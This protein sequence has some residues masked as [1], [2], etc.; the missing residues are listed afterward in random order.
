MTVNNSRDSLTGLEVAVIGMAC[1]FPGAKDLLSFWENLK[2]AKTSLSFLD[3]DELAAAKAKFPEMTSDKNYVPSKGGVINEWDSFDN[4]F[5]NYS[6]S[7]AKVLHPQTRNFLECVWHTLEDAG[8]S[9]IT[10]KQPIGVFCSC[11]SSFYWQA[12]TMLSGIRE[13]IGEFLAT[14]LSDSS[15]ASSITSYKLN[16]TGPSMTLNTACSSSL[17]AI[18]QA[19]RALLMGECSMAIAGGVSLNTLPKL[20][21]VYVE[22]MINSADGI[23]RTFD[24]DAKGTVKGEGAGVVMLKP[25]KKAVADGDKIYA[26]IKGSAINNDGN[27]KVGYAAS[28]VSGQAEVIRKAHKVAQVDFNTIGYIETH[29]TG[30][31]LGDVVELEALREAYGSSSHLCKIGSVKTN[32]GHLDAAAGVAGFIKTVLSLYYKKI[33]PSLNFKNANPGFDFE[34]SPFSVITKIED[35]PAG[36]WPYRAS[37][38]SFGIG[39]TN[40]HVIL[41]VCEHGNNN[42]NKQERPFLIKL[43]A[44]SKNSLIAYSKELAGFLL[45]YPDI[46]INNIAFTLNVRRRQHLYKR[47]VVANDISTLRNKLLGYTAEHFVDIDQ[48][49]KDAQVIFMLPGQG[50]Q[51]VNMGLS[52]YRVEPYFKETV[53]ECFRLCSKQVGH[54]LY[55]SMTEAAYAEEAINNTEYTQLIVFIFQYS[56]TKLLIKW[57]VKPAAFIGHSLGE[58]TVA[59]LTGVLSLKDTVD[60]L[61]YRG[62][63]AVQAPNGKTLFVRISE[64]DLLNYLHRG[65]NV[66][67][68]NNSRSYTLSGSGNNIDA[69]CS[70]FRAANIPYVVLN[71]SIGFHSHLMEQAAELLSMKALDIKVLTPDVPF[72]SNV[73][74]D[75]IKPEQ[76]NDKYWGEQLRSTV[77][78]K[79]GIDT[80]LTTFNNP[81]FVEIG[82]DMVL[83]GIVKQHL[84]YSSVQR[85]VISVMPPK[86]NSENELDKILAAIGKLWMLNIPVNWMELQ[87]KPTVSSVNLPGY[88][89][90]KKRF[91]LNIDSSRAEMVSSLLNP[92]QNNDI[93]YYVPKWE[94]SFLPPETKRGGSESCYLIIAS[95]SH[96]DKIAGSINDACRIIRILPSHQYERKDENTILL[97][98]KG[99][100]H[101]DQLF[102]DVSLNERIRV[103]HCLGLTEPGEELNVN[104]PEHLQNYFYSVL[105]LVK[106]LN[107]VVISQEQEFI[108]LSNKVAD[109]FDN[110]DILPLKY[111][112][113]GA[114]KT[115]SVEYPNV[116][117]KLVDIELTNEPDCLLDINQILAKEFNYFDNRHLVVHRYGSRWVKTIEPIKLNNNDRLL[118]R[119]DKHNYI[120]TGAF[121]GIGL[122]IIKHLIKNYNANI[123]AIVRIGFP[124]RDNWDEYITSNKDEKTRN[125]IK[126]ILDIEEKY[127]THITVVSIDISNEQSISEVISDFE[128]MHGDITGVIHAAGEIDTNGIIQN[129]NNE[130][131]RQVMTAKINGTIAITNYFKNRP[132][133]FLAL[134]SS[135]GNVLYKSKFGQVG[136]I[137]SNEFI[138]AYGVYCNLNFS[139]KTTVIH[140]NDWKEVGLTVEAAKRKHKHEDQEFDVEEHINGGL[141]IAEGLSVF[142][143]AI[144]SG[145]D[146]VIVSTQDL[147]QKVAGYDSEIGGDR[148]NISKRRDSF[149][150]MQSLRKNRD[151][152]DKHLLV[153][154]IFREYVDDP[155][156]DINDDFFEKGGDSLKAIYLLRRLE[157]EFGIEISIHFLYENSTA[158]KIACFIDSMNANVTGASANIIHSFFKPSVLLKHSVGS[159]RVLLLFPPTAAYAFVYEKFASLIEGYSIHGFNFLPETDRNQKYL[160]IIK[161][162]ETSYPFV[163]MGYSAG[164]A[165]AF[166]LCKTMEEGGVEVS[167]L[168]LL[169]TY[170]YRVHHKDGHDAYVFDEFIKSAKSLVS[171]LHYEEY[172]NEII[173]NINA[174]HKFSGELVSSGKINAN[175]HLLKAEDRF[176]EE[177]RFKKLL[178]ER[179]KEFTE[180]S[181]LTNGNYFE[182][183]CF[184][185]HSQLISDNF[186]RQNIIIC[187]KILNSIHRNT[188]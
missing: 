3:D 34:N 121:G 180:W 17:V 29:G 55:P 62:E 140:W 40:A 58:L 142:E 81:V 96:A 60:L 25:Y 45:K 134:F 97:D 67:A 73:T 20:G 135:C 146:N 39:G 11:S 113:L 167:D 141:T 38:S 152:N 170:S 158:F 102:K 91:S 94:Q 174:Y 106:A 14:T 139:F 23:C 70:Q 8:Y 48:Q 136:Y 162:I 127:S 98:I 28:S 148:T 160:E 10:E 41:E 110:G 99:A 104:D 63:L 103:V 6:I 84:L 181:N 21:Y 87:S 85:E 100:E 112:V 166:E 1:N 184:G 169:D 44:N 124:L 93:K 177:S 154:N 88:V 79:K 78:F 90:D 161:G 71:E 178:G 123:L 89:F 144:S 9:H 151:D 26:V 35:W 187:N 107:K 149:V 116:K 24:K 185:K 49:P 105:N 77:Q 16:F 130:S 172:E 30:T 114:V 47:W 52:L 22:G 57:G 64:Q 147:I 74:G 53:D 179:T 86:K 145:Y 75:W 182:Y 5:F 183:N 125:R 27:R 156:Y 129:R 120:V 50:S 18:H 115:I 2:D 109:I 131:T 173:N 176:E 101:Y 76:L 43:T 155:H 54:I 164:G 138:E 13:N 143:Q 95:A 137:S 171:S 132:L 68:I 117:I 56:L 157:R 15:F 165:L 175:I 108:L 51:Y 32:I 122:S 19:C 126:E 153:L 46:S 37:V 133:T 111:T 7:E 72:I 59:C 128:K 80:I 163:V 65:I 36:S 12:Q 31:V 42:T 186:F 92:Q 66:A 188:P 119:L 61:T 168:I 159:E 118:A 69:V 82:P 4:V 83:S 150:N 33:V